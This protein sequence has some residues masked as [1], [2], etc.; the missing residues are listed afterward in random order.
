MPGFLLTRLHVLSRA[1]P[2]L[3]GEEERP[4]APLISCRVSRGVCLGKSVSPRWPGPGWRR[5]LP[6][7]GV[8]VAFLLAPLE[9]LLVVG[10]RLLRGLPFDSLRSWS[11]DLHDDRSGRERCSARSNGPVIRSDRAGAHTD[12]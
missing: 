12:R 7:G 11:V 8:L 2:R 6:C 9:N 4:W 10:S 5:E 1:K 3:K